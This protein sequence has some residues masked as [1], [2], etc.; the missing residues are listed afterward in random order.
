LRAYVALHLLVVEGWD[1][2][3]PIARMLRA[4]DGTVRT[5]FDRILRYLDEE[6]WQQVVAWR[7]RR[8]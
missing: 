4:P 3:P 1:E 6:D 8:T 5:G 2:F 7:E